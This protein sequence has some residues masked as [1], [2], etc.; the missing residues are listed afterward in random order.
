[1]TTLQLVRDNYKNNSQMYQQYTNYDKDIV[2]YQQL[3][4]TLFNPLDYNIRI[5]GLFI[6]KTEHTREC[7]SSYGIKKINYLKSYTFDSNGNVTE[8][9]Y[10]GITG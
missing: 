6:S 9:D 10:M 1:M 4:A 5:D 3:T 2:T 8:I 7:I